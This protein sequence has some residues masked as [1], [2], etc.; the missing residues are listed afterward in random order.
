MIMEKALVRNTRGQSTLMYA[1]MINA[2]HVW[3]SL[4]PQV[5]A[6][7]SLLTFWCETKSH[8]FCNSCS[9]QKSGAIPRDRK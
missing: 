7:F 3:N 6:A 4:P 1:A 9:W 5:T 2:V 8:H